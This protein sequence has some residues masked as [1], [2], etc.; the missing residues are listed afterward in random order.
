MRSVRNEARLVQG[1]LLLLVCT[2]YLRPIA[3]HMM[4]LVSPDIKMLQL[5]TKLRDHVKETGENQKITNRIL[6]EPCWVRLGRRGMCRL[7]CRLRRT[8]AVVTQGGRHEQ[9]APAPI[10]REGIGAAQTL[11]TLLAMGHRTCASATAATTARASPTMPTQR[12]LTCVQ[13]T[14]YLRLQ[15]ASCLGLA[16]P[17][18]SMAWQA[19]DMHRRANGLGDWVESQL[20]AR[21]YI[22]AFHKREM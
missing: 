17:P 2:I 7:A 21:E 18:M 8:V 6:E 19:L 14:T 1:T 11:L 22:L 16:S 9:R 12:R 4:L 15:P 5:M 13:P 3:A 10:A 20:T